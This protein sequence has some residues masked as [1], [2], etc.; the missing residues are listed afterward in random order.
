MEKYLLVVR[1]ELTNKRLTYEAK[2]NLG[3]N[4]AINFRILKNQEFLQL[5]DRPKIGMS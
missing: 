3:K 2:L 1:K 5:L 4:Q